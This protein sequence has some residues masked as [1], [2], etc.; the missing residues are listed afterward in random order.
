LKENLWEAESFEGW[1]SVMNTNVSG[2][3]FTTISFLPLLQAAL[4]HNFAPRSP[5]VIV[6]SS[7]SGLMRNS[8]GH[9]GYPFRAS[10]PLSEHLKSL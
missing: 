7:M 6:I 5:S 3:Y 10:L 1:A 8:Q 4:N 2:V 9:V